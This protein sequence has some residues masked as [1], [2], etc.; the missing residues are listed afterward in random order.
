[1][2]MFHILNIIYSRNTKHVILLILIANKK[3][4]HCDHVTPAHTTYYNRGQNLWRKY[5]VKI[6]PH[7]PIQC[8][9]KEWKF[10]RLI[11]TK[12]TQATHKQRW[13]WGSGGFSENRKICPQMSQNV[14]SFWEWL[15]GLLAVVSSL[16]EYS[17]ETM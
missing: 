2:K 1:M 4:F 7:S 10:S 8:Y 16:V 14:V 12:V 6:P 11:H 13:K 15:L 3:C 9:P 17:K 5:S